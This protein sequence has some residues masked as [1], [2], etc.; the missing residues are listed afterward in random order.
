MWF[1]GPISAGSPKYAPRGNSGL[2]VWRSALFGLSSPLVT[3]AFKPSRGLSGALPNVK[4]TSEASV[5]ALNVSAAKAAELIDELKVVV[6]TCL[7]SPNPRANGVPKF[8]GRALFEAR[9]LPI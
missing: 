4:P 5:H 9:V 1:A 8:V 2:N 7:V 3:F 6:P